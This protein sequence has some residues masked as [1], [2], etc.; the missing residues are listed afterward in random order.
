MSSTAEGENMDTGNADPKAFAWDPKSPAKLVDAAGSGRDVT[1]GTTYADNGVGCNTFESSALMKLLDARDAYLKNNPDAVGSYPSMHK[2]CKE[3]CSIMSECAMEWGDFLKEKTQEAE[4]EDMDVEK[5]TR[6]SSAS[7]EGLELLQLVFALTDLSGTFLLLPGQTGPRNLAGAGGGGLDYYEDTISQPGAVTA[8]TVRFLRR[9]VLGAVDDQFDDTEFAEMYDS[10]QPDQFNGGDI[11]W[12]AIEANLIRGYLEEAWLLLSNHS[13]ARRLNEVD[14][15]QDE[16]MDEYLRA[17][18]AE[19]RDGFLALRQVLLSAPIPG[20]RVESNDDAE[21][22]DQMV[23]TEDIDGISNLAYQLWDATDNGSTFHF[24]PRH[25]HQMWQNWQQTIKMMPELH[26][27]RS[28]IPQLNRLLDMLSGDF[29]Q[30]Q[31][32]SWSDELCADLLYKIP[33]IKMVDICARTKD[34]MK[35]DPDKSSADLKEGIASIMNGNAGS[36]ISLAYKLGGSSGAAL[37]ATVTS[38]LCQLF[39]DAGILGDPSESDPQTIATTM[40][41]TSAITSSLAVEGARDLGARLVARLLL[42]LI[43][44]GSDIQYTA[45]L[46]ETLEHHSPSSDSD[47]KSLLAL[48]RK[49]VERKNVRVLDGC[50]AICM[51]RYVQ[52]KKE[53]RPGGAVFWLLTGIE[54]ESLVLCDGANRSGSWQNALSHGVCYRKLVAD[55]SETA[56]L[57]IKCLIGIQEEDGAATVYARAQEMV[58]RAQEDSTL[59]PFIRPVKVLENVVT[60][61]TAI[62]ERK[63]NSIVANGI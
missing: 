58:L 10:V 44:I 20:G 28:R 26:R 43:K 2:L 17:S 31:F 49:L 7:A 54:L 1:I 12:K 60:M 41:A 6:E 29:R 59:T 53:G 52:Y 56:Q 48:C 38:L 33:D 5:V 30:V 13:M 51:A 37:P 23:D 34:V 9:H 18:L 46:V 24:E 42:P 19:D 15:E 14:M 45:A 16:G 4:E 35:A 36:V 21:I 40:H 3:Y 50:D 62:Y 57:M 32:A 55:F 61:A 11:Y 8:E 39:S 27:L 22:G 63:S 47:A 25:A